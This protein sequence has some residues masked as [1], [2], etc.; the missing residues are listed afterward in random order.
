MDKTYESII[1]HS[2]Y[3]ECG[4]TTQMWIIRIQQ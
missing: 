1:T 4:A 3:I 2:L